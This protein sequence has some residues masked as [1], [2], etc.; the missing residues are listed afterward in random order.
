MSFLVEVNDRYI[1]LVGI[2]IYLGS[3]AVEVGFGEEHRFAAFIGKQDAY[4]F[5]VFADDGALEV[6]VSCVKL[7]LSACGTNKKI[8]LFSPHEQS[9]HLQADFKNAQFHHAD[10]FVGASDS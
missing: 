9:R 8:V 7:E 10:D 1:V 3:A 5:V 2:Y 4:A 6:D